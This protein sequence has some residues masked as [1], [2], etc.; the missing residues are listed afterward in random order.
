MIWVLLQ[1]VVATMGFYEDTE[2]IPPRMSV[3]IG[4]PL[5]TILLLF[6]LPAG[7]RW[8]Y[9]LDMRT[10]IMLHVVRVPVE[11]GLHGLFLQGDVP[12][13]MTYEGRNFD[14]F[15]GLT[16]PLVA[17]LG[18]RHG[19]VNRP[20]LIGWNLLCLALLLNIMFHGIFSVP[21]PFQLFGFERPN[22]ALLHF[23]YVWLPAVI[24]PLV[25]LAHAA[26]LHQLLKPEHPPVEHAAR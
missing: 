3:A 14:I 23:P 4:P 8:S 20:L 7:R 5:L 11:I 6:V 10:L 9:R 1:G 21:T 25:L 26:A 18:F 12:Q 22:V 17:T 2:G 16:A 15:S 13:V 19:R 24:V